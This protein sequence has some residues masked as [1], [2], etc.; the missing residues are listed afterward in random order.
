MVK[1]DA[2]LGEHLERLGVDRGLGQPHPL[3][4][5]AEAVLEVADP[6]AHLGA[7]VAPLASGRIMW[8]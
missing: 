5:A 3:G 1:R 6:P 7:L 8:L 2:V 4:L